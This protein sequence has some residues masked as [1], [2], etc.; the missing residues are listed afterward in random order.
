VDPDI[1]QQAK[2][3][4]A[5]IEIRPTISPAVVVFN[6]FICLFVLFVCLLLVVFER[7]VM[8]IFLLLLAI[9][10]SSKLF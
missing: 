10:F 1:S 2:A 5:D 4:V 9:V 3:T 8:R 6:F 7:N